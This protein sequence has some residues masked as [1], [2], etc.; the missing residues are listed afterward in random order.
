MIKGAI[1]HIP[2]LLLSIKLEDLMIRVIL[3]T[4]PKETLFLASLLLLVPQPER[5]S[6]ER[7]RPNPTWLVHTP[8]HFKQGIV[9]TKRET[10]REVVVH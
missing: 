10:Q 1:H 3:S 6:T 2:C 4:I 8:H 5:P 7:E 9:D